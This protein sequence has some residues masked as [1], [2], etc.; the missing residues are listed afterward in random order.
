M[1]RWVL[2]TEFTEKERQ[3][4]RE[5]HRQECLC[6]GL[7]L[8]TFD[9][10]LYTVLKRENRERYKVQGLRF[11]EEERSRSKDRPAHKSKRNLAEM[12]RSSAAPLRLEANFWFTRGILA[13]TVFRA[14]VT[15]NLPS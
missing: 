15:V 9:F 14:C 10:A 5:E 1:S 6:H 4:H 12:G 8:F 11:V 2:N 3:G 13:L 7:V